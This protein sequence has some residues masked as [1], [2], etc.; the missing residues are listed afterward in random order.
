[1]KSVY[2]NLAYVFLFS[3]K[4]PIYKQD[5]QS[6]PTPTQSGAENSLVQVCLSITKPFSPFYLTSP[7]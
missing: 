5:K 2:F 6:Q 1:M 3:A 4:T 7:F